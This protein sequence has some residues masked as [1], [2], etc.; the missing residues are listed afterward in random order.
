MSLLSRRAFTQTTMGSLLTFSLLEFLYERDAFAASV[1]PEAARWFADVNTLGMDLK[2]EKITQPQ[3]QAKLEELLARVELTEL[4][5]LIDFEQLQKNA[6]LPDNG[7]RSLRFSFQQIEGVPKQLAYGKQVFAM[8]Q[9]R[10]VVPHGHNNMATAFI[11][12]QGEFAGRHY[13]R[14]EDQTKHLIIRPTIDRR[15]GPADYSTVT[16]QK[17]NIH[18]FKAE[19]K[20]G[21]L[22]NLHALNVNPGG[23]K[24]TGRVYLDPNGEK[25]KDGLIRAPRINHDQAHKLYG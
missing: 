11:V 6:N 24:K 8:K 16:D 5:K 10:S 1:K 3:W 17:D 19:S 2:G 7:A 21:F 4:M 9:G 25:L 20:T 15:F 18:W 14:I 22:F 23:D 13:D 12:L